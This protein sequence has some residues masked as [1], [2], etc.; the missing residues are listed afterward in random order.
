M[1]SLTICFGPAG[2][3]W[4][5]MFRTQEAAAAAATGYDSIVNA[6]TG[7]LILGDDFGQTLNMEAKDLHGCVLED[8]SLSKAAHIER[9]LHQARMQAEGQQQAE[10]DAILRAAR[11]RS[12]PAIIDPM[13]M[14]RGNFPGNGYRG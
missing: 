1:F 13:G 5:L 12:G 6:G 2:T 10:T 3:M 4:Q 9:A 11:A 8:L 14:P 7:R